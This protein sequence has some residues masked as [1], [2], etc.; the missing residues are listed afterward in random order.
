MTKP[1]HDQIDSKLPVTAAAARASGAVF[2]FTGTPC[3]HGHV[4][5]RYARSSICVECQSARSKV[6]IAAHPEAVQGYREKAKPKAAQYASR[7]RALNPE[8]CNQRTQA[9]RDKNRDRL[10][11]YDAARYRE[12]IDAS[13]AES[14]AYYR[15]NAEAMQANSKRWF[16]ANRD[17]ARALAREWGSNNPG[18]MAQYRQ[19]RRALENGAV[20][21][22][23]ADDIAR[24]IEAQGGC[25]K[26]CGEKRNLTVDHILALSRGGSNWPS[27]LQMLCRPC[28]S[29]KKNHDFVEFMRRRAALA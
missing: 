8:L 9:W 10:R 2:Y 11:A 5:K 12:D 21:S 20:G 4:S 23:L 27:N 22:F 1:E 13:R 14:R 6:W 25:C 19:N 28:N 15:R 7:H 29:S 3:K 17:R 26:V 18:K 24:L 16:A